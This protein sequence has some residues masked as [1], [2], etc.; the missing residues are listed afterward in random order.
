MA[1][2]LYEFHG[3]NDSFMKIASYE[4]KK[5]QAEVTVKRKKIKENLNVL[6][7]FLIPRNRK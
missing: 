3:Q 1:K 6:F 5:A 2:N 7:F 4:A